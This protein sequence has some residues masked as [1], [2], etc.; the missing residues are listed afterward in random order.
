M[1]QSVFDLNPVAQTEGERVG[2]SV[3]VL[4]WNG[5][6]KL[7]FPDGLNQTQC[8]QRLATAATLRRQN[9]NQ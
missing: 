5:R 1:K 7:Q 3:G 6:L 9:K 4:F 8:C 2:S